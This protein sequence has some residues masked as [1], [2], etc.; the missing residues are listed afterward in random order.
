[1]LGGAATL[2]Y[3]AGMNYLSNKRKREGKNENKFLRHA[4]WAVPT[5]TTL[6][7]PISEGMATRRGIK[8]LR[9]AGASK[10]YI[11]HTKKQLGKAQ[12]SYAGI[13]LVF[14]G[15]SELGRR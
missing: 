9:E 7:L 1:M 12:L 5:I 3:G 11:K 15:L 2:A 6:P 4:T 10:E 13:P 8:M 14:A